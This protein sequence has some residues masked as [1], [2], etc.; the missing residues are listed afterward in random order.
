MHPPLRRRKVRS[1]P[2]PPAAKTAPAPLLLLSPPRGARRG[3]LF[4]LARK[5]NGPCTVQKKRALS[6]LRC[7]GPPRATGVGVSVPAP[8]LPGL[9]ARLGLLRFL[10]LPS[11]GGLCG[12]QRGARTHL[13]SF[14]FRAFRFATRCPGG[15]RGCC[16]GPCCSSHQPPASGSENRRRVYPSTSPGQRFPQEPGVSVPDCCKGPPAI[17][18]RRQEVC[19][20][21][22]RPAEF[23]TGR[24]AFSS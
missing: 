22:D 24:G 1:A 19:A 2:F 14:S 4:G 9:R 23:S 10:Q 13:T 21:A 3:P 12:G 16:V 18:R 8:I 20:C 5:E 7:S 15:R 6:V 11:R 17:P